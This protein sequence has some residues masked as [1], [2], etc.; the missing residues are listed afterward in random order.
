MLELAVGTGRLAVP[1]AERGIDVVG[2]DTSPEMLARLA[3]RDPT[4][5]GHRVV[6][7][8][9]DDLPAGPFDVVLIAY[10]SLFNLRHRAATQ[11]CFAAVAARLAPDGVF[12]VEAFVPDDP[13]RSGS[14]VAVR[15]MSTS[16]VVLSISEHDPDA[17]RAHGHFVSVRRRRA[18]A[19]AAVGD[20]LR[21]AGRAR[22]DGGCG[23]RSRVVERWEDFDRRPFTDDSPRHVTVY[24]LTR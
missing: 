23:R 11:A 9:V 17:Q 19:A 5:H 6:G 22:R 16:E 15:S 4:R 20:P 3:A 21:P 10:N 18:R 2:V 8:M 7:D 12:V 24:A 1:I 14:V 13:P